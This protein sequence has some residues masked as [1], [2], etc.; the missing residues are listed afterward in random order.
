MDTQAPS[1]IGTDLEPVRLLGPQR[2]RDDALPRDAPADEAAHACVEEM[3]MMMM[4]GFSLVF[5]DR[6]SAI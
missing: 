6:G 1:Y 2:V 3:M 4:I 5:Q